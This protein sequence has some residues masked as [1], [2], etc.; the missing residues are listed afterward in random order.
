[1]QAQLKQIGIDAKIVSYDIGTYWDK[2]DGKRIRY[3]HDRLER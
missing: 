2:V 1:M 3:V